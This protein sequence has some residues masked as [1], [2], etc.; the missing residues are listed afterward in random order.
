MKYAYLAIAGIVVTLLLIGIAV[1]NRNSYN[2][3]V[4]EFYNTRAADARESDYSIVTRGITFG[5]NPREVNRRMGKPPESRTL[6]TNSQSEDEPYMAHFQF[7]HKSDALGGLLQ[8]VQIAEYYHVFFD[9]MK[10][11]TRIEYLL[12]DK[13]GNSQEIIANLE[14]RTLSEPLSHVG[15]SLE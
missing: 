5:M 7:Q 6:T 15:Q 11:A 8:Q 14:D 1:W 3:A 13:G 2:D 4:E 12:F 10:R 9:P